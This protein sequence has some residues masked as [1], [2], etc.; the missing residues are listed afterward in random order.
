MGPSWKRSERRGL[1]AAEGCL[2]CAESSGNVDPLHERSKIGTELPYAFAARLQW[3]MDRRHRFHDLVLQLS[4]P[5]LSFFP[6]ARLAVPYALGTREL[7]I[8]LAALDVRVDHDFS[9]VVLGKPA[10]DLRH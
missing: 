2:R 4:L 10:L 6:S 7:A 1:G 8:D 3:K 5:R 9:A